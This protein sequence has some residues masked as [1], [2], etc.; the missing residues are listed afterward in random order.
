[1]RAHEIE[2][3]HAKIGQLI[4]RL[5]SRNRRS[6]HPQSHG[7]LLPMCALSPMRSC[8]RVSLVTTPLPQ[9]LNERNVRTAPCQ[10]RPV[11]QE[12]GQRVR[13]E[14]AAPADQCRS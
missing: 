1:D 2:W 8:G 3:F 10:G 4:L 11:K 12:L 7:D 5:A 14:L 13:F 6:E 9:R